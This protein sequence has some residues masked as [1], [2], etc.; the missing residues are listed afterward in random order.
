MPHADPEKR[1]EYHKQYYI[2]NRENEVEQRKQY[3]TENKEKIK[4]RAIQY[5]LN[6]KE[7]VIEY[8]KNY[9]DQNKEKVKERMKQYHL[10]NQEKVKDRKKEYYL[11][12]KCEHDKGKGGCKICNIYQYLVKLQRS[13]VQRI[14]KST[15]LN[16]TKST[17][18]YLDC[19]PEYFKEYLQKKMIDGMSFD[20]IHIDHIKPVSKFNLEDPDELLKCCHYT[21][22][23][24]LLAY[25]NIVKS[26]KWNDEDD[27]FWNENIIH[28]EYLP[29]YLPK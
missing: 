10:N 19:S 11:K 6:N 16:K 18:E 12:S 29:L 9:E 24:P 20:N 28:K 27:A 14:I 2:R 22:M 3:Y 8:Q 13:Q 25:D 15:T 23:Q 17:I 4:E 26:D 1:K 21:N 7:K 5:Y